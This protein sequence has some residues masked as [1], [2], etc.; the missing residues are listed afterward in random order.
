MAWIISYIFAECWSTIR[1]G[2]KLYIYHIF[3]ECCFAML[4][5]GKIINLHPEWSLSH[6]SWLCMD[7]K[8]SKSTRFLPKDEG[9]PFWPPNFP[10][11]HWIWTRISSSFP[12]LMSLLPLLLSNFHMLYRVALHASALKDLAV[13]KLPTTQNSS[14]HECHQVFIHIFLSLYLMSTS[15]SATGLLVVLPF[16]LPSLNI[17][18]PQNTTPLSGEENTGTQAR[19]RLPWNSKPSGV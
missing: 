19:L 4:F 2:Y 1:K 10:S 15:S 17:L 3:V 11:N 8:S 14:R 12:A 5:G 16:F 9:S 7:I 18:E 6:L 13:S